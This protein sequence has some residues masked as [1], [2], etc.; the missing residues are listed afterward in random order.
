MLN[1][2]TAVTTIQDCAGKAGIVEAVCMCVCVSIIR[3]KLKK[4]DG[5]KLM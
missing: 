3:T 5:Q 1:R 2:L 4:T